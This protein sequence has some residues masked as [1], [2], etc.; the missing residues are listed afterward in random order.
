MVGFID[1]HRDEYGVEPICEQLPISPSTYY[2]M[3]APPADPARLPARTRRD[4]AL[5]AEIGRVHAANF[6]VYGA[7]KVWRPPVSYTHLT[8]PTTQ[9]V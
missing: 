3:K 7:R 4:G 9:P 1:A 5:K 2:E 6:G 8:L